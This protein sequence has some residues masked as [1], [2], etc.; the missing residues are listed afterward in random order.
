MP[1]Y[2]VTYE[3]KGEKDYEKIWAALDDL[4]SV[5]VQRTHYLVS[6]DHRTAADLR[7]H[8]KQFVDKNDRLMVIEFTK[9]PSFTM[10]QK[11]TRKWLNSK[12]R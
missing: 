10:A 4:D 1:L 11:G 2:S 3:L 8:L 12:F 9:I 5:K 6:S 7:T